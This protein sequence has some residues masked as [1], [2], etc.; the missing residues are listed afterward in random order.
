MPRPVVVNTLASNESP[1]RRGLHGTLGVSGRSLKTLLRADD[2]QLGCNHL[3]PMTCPTSFADSF[4]LG[5][6]RGF[7]LLQ[8]AGLSAEARRDI[9]SATHGSLDFEEVSRALQTLWDEQFIGA[10]AQVSHVSNWH[11]MAVVEEPEPQ[12]DWSWDAFQA[13]MAW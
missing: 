11:E 13:E 9:L 8:S 7:R 5:V 6:L 2:G 12:D 10:R 1:T 3:S 4:V